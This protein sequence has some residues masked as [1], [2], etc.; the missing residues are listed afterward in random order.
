M[1]SFEQQI[2][3]RAYHLWLTAG[4]GEG[5]SHEHWTSAER[6]LKSEKVELDATRA[7]AATTLATKT[8]SA[9]TSVTKAS[10]STKPGSKQTVGTNA[11]KTAKRALAKGKSFRATKH[12]SIGSQIQPTH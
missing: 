2:R 3:E 5:M 7:G 6:A 8:A 4:Q 9:D 1:D 12:P 11:K 10:A